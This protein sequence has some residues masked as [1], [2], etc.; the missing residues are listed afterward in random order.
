METR[1]ILDCV[2]T[3]AILLDDI[4]YFSRV[5]LKINIEGLIHEMVQKYKD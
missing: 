5:L 3:F 4:S 2:V 1:K